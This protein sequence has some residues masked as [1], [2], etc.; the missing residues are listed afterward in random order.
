MYS[1]NFTVS[2][3]KFYLSLYYNRE[4]SYLFVDGT[5]IIKF[6]SKDPEIVGT[7]FCLGNTSKDQSVDDMKR[8]GLYGYICDFPVDYD[9]ITIDDILD[10]HKYLMKKNMM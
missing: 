10:I 5:E 7:P 2:K 8:T 1:I 6:K 4:N 9:A 3:K